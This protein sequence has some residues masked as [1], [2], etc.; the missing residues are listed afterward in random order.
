MMSNIPYY[1][2]DKN[3]DFDREKQARIDAYPQN[4]AL[5]AAAREFSLQTIKA[6]YSYNFTWMGRPIIQYPQD[7]LA[8]QEI[9]WQVQPDLV[10]ETGVAHGGSLIYYASLLEMLGGEGEVLGIDIEV[11][12]HNYGEIVRHPMSKR[13]SMIE[14]SSIADATAEK[15]YEFARN[16]KRILISLD[17]NHTHEHVLSE[18]KLYADLTTVGSYC[19]VFDTVV[20]ELPEDL[21]QERPWGVGDNPMTAARE[22]LKTRDDFQIDLSIQNK[23]LVTVAPNGYLKRI[24]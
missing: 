8:M 20:E 18:L 21:F 11:R 2:S 16:K 5:Q 12:S 10:I 17:S 9:I 24:K 22:F 13:I 15:V 6:R 23:L 19:V 7:M 4:D 14:G 1:Q 3:S